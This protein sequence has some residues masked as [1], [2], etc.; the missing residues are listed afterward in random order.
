MRTWALLGGLLLATAF[1]RAQDGLEPPK[2]SKER[3]L[4]F[5]APDGWKAVAPVE[6]ERAAWTVRA[7]E[8]AP[9]VRVSLVKHRR[10]RALEDHV[11][12]WSRTFDGATPEQE[13]IPLEKAIDG[14]SATLVA[15]RGAYVAPTEPGDEDPRRREGWAAL[16][17]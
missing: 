15:L 6:P 10:K 1:V 17:A 4:I 8:G 13:S 3:G 12:R 5:T 11:A 16:H 9:R 7:L 2:V 14:V